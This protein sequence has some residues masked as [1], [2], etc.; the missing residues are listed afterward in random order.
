VLTFQ[1]IHETPQVA[2]ENYLENE[3]ETFEQIKHQIEIFMSK[4]VKDINEV[5][6]TVN[7][8]M[9]SLI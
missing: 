3:K 7:Q 2:F 1:R 8:I 9:T 4:D 5:S 6:I